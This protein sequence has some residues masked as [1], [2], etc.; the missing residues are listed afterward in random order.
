MAAR[1]CG[2]EVDRVNKLSRSRRGSSDQS[3]RRVGIFCNI[4]SFNIQILQLTPF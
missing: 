4:D 1:S 2:V 3:N